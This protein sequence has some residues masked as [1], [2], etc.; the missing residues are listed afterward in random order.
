MKYSRVA[1]S[2][3][4]IEQANEALADAQILFEKG[5][6]ANVIV[7]V[8]R[9]MLCAT[10]ALLAL[11]GVNAFKEAGAL[12]LLAHH[13][14]KKGLISPECFKMMRTAMDMRIKSEKRDFSLLGKD[15]VYDAIN[16]AKYF[17]RQ[18]R[19]ALDGLIAKLQGET[20]D[21]Q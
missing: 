17:Q 3:F 1:L 4:R 15:E 19:I 5:S 10:E 6:P 20:D 7:L 18:V 13:F 2:K 8:Y 14:V 9:S 21:S 16:K 12:K 11:I